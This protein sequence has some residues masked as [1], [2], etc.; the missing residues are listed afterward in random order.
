M[1]VSFNLSPLTL[2]IV[3]VV[4]RAFRV[5][6]MPLSLFSRAVVRIMRTAFQQYVSN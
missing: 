5:K 2:L 3:L 6:Q 1:Y 4:R